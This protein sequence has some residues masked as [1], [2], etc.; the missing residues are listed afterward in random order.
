MRVLKMF[1]AEFSKGY[2]LYKEGKLL[3]EFS[4]DT[5]GWY[6]LD[7]ELAVKFTVNGEDHP[8]FIS[9]IPLIIDLDSAQALDRKKTM[10]KLLKI[11]IQKMPMDKNGD[12]IFDVDEAQQ[13]HNNAVQMLGK[14]IGIDVLTTFAD[15]TVED[16]SDSQASAQTDDLE[17]VERQL[18]NEAGVSQMQFNT[19]GNL[20]LE[21]SV[22]ND[23]ATMYN[24]LLQ[25]E[26]FLNDLVSKF[27]K[28]SNKITYKVQIFPPPSPKSQVPEPSPRR[29]VRVLFS[30]PSGGTALPFRAKKGATLCPSQV[31]PKGFISCSDLRGSCDPRR[32]LRGWHPG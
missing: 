5:S 23:E 13:L 27:G 18:Y 14:A 26:R 31:A 9:V 6:L 17:R 15:V 8:A 32:A 12:L 20:A 4:G 28:N 21:K 25:F 22:L 3:P 16:M 10:Q 19:S 1:P 30:F 7:P 24:M 29:P 11:V 2:T